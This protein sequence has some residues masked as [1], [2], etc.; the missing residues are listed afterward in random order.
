MKIRKA[1]F[2][3]AGLGTRVLPATKAMP[4]EM[5][6]IVDRPLIQYVVDEAKEAGIE[7]FIFVTGRNKGMIEDHFDR[8]FELDVTLEKRNKKSEMELLARDQPEAGAMSFTRQQ[9][10]LGL[11]HAVWCARDIVG[12]E[13]FAVVLPDELVL[14]SPGCLA[15]MIKAAETL[16]EKANVI[17]VEEVPADKTHQYG[18][19]GVGKRDGK[20]FEI[21]GMVEKPAPGT[22][23][24]NLSISGR[25][26]L[27]PEIFKIL[28]TQERGAGGEIQLTDAMIGLAK[29]QKFYGV[30][31]EGER[32]DCG[33]KAGF[34]R[35]NIA[36]AMQRP[37]LR[38]D[39]RA[40]MKRYLGD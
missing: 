6:T 8:Q 24:S 2:P 3:V 20:M 14:N 10:P 27:Q 34:L 11:G 21:D 23:P 28:A 35:A 5:L 31:F 12:N 22:A 26:I 29:T 25:Y 13:P 19:C 7:H 32:H 30:E 18:I 33:S 37:D 16:G 40:T 38:D 4:K 1:V 17:A 15:Q 39:L 36:F 9:A